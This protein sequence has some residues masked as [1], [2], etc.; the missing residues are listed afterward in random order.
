M[1]NVDKIPDVLK[2]QNDISYFIGDWVFLKLKTYKQTSLTT[3]HF[4]KLRQRYFG[5]F[6]ILE[7]IEPVVIDY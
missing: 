7:Q 4:H 5:P 2:K 6:K 1:N 3:G